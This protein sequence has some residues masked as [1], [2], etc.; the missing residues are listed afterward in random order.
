MRGKELKINNAFLK[1]RYPETM[2]EAVITLV[3]A[4]KGYLVN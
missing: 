4:G 3:S 1:I 2:K